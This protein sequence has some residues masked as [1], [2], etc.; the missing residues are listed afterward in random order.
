MPNISGYDYRGEDLPTEGWHQAVIE[1]SQLKK[2][3][4][5]NGEY[6][7]VRFQLLTPEGKGAHKVWHRYN[8]Q[9]PNPTAQGIGRRQL[10]ELCAACG[11][12]D[13]QTSEELHRIPLMVK[14][15]HKQSDEFG[16]Q[17][18]IASTQQE[19]GSGTR[20]AP[21]RPPSQPRPTRRGRAGSTDRPAP[22]RDKAV[23]SDMTPNRT[24]QQ[25]SRRPSLLKARAAAEKASRE[26]AQLESEQEQLDLD[27]EYEAYEEEQS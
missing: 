15:K 1:S 27:A 25:G 24:A 6:L 5:G 7:E 22:A 14:I 4:A 9:N 8:V 18:E 26:A 23:G 21:P 11:I 19:G 3:K 20:P 17:P 12:P 16:V 13:A 10:K 2:N